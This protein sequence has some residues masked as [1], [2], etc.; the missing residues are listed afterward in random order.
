[1][2]NP[3][4]GDQCKLSLNDEV[5]CPTPPETK[6]T[7]PEAFFISP[8]YRFHQETALWYKRREIEYALTKGTHYDGEA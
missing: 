2:G 3:E 4:V 7:L 5:A 8:D 6:Y 1:V